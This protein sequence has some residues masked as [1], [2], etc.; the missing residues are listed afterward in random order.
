MNQITNKNINIQ[1][2]TFEDVLMYKDSIK[3][4][5][6][7]SVKMSNYEE[8]YTID[9]AIEKTNELY[10]YVYNNKAIVIGAFYESIL[11][12]F[13]WAYEYPFREDSNRLY[14]SIVHVLEEYRNMHIGAELLSCVENIA[15]NKGY[16]KLFLHAEATN[17]K[18]C[19]FY[20]SNKY[21]KERIQ[22]VKS[23]ANSYK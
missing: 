8:S 2:M 21:E 19:R 14:I 18:A 5:I 23:I 20:Q 1:Q 7:E 16:D 4:F 3:I 6:Y 15:K 17:D 12:G 11:I 13:L 22:Y 10:D 9:Q